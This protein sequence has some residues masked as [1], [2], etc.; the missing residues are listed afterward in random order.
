MIRRWLCWALLPLLFACHEEDH[1]IDAVTISFAEVD[2]YAQHADMAYKSE[3]EIRAA[4]PGTVLVATTRGNDVQYY[5]EV[6]PHT[7]TQVIAVRGTANLPN[8]REDAK[9]VESRNPSLG[10]YVHDGFD[11]GA[12]EIFN[13]LQP[14]LDKSRPVIVTGHS[15]GAAIATLLMMMLHEEGYDLKPSINFGQ[16][17]VTNRAGVQKYRN[18]PLLRIA[19]ENDIVPLLPPTDLVDSV[20]GAYEHLGPELI[21]LPGKYYVYQTHHQVER[22]DVDSFWDNLGDE[23]IVQHYMKNYLQN[24]AAKLRESQAVPF[25]QR[26]TYIKK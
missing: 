19:D 5:L 21:L 17:K 2:W 20:H 9:Y 23:S 8:I 10:I 7:G 1:T 15:L 25:D 6:E 3:A 22:Y 13:A 18:L 11:A 24:I 4:Y 12:W 14:H 16:P 26:E